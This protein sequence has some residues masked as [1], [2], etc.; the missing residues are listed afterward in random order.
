M[1]VGQPSA[2]HLVAS[3]SRASLRR[4]GSLSIHVVWTIGPV[5]VRSLPFNSNTRP[6]ADP[7]HS[8]V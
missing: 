5:Y 6:G 3:S 2:D 8:N 1:K 7:T 4:E